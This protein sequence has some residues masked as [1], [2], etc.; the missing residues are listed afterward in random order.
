MG[1][2]TL[3]TLVTEMLGP[4]GPLI[5]I[6]VLGIILIMLAISLYANR[7]V[8]PYEKFSQQTRAMDAGLPKADRLR[9]GKNNEQLDKYST[10]LEP[11]DAEEFSAVK[12]RLLQAGYRGQDAVRTYHFAQFAL[13]LGLLALG[14]IFVIYQSATSEP[15]TQKMV[16]TAL[17]PGVIGYMAPKYWVTKRLQTRQEEITN[18]FPDALDMMLV[19]VEAGQ[20]LDQSILR[21]AT[22]IR[23]SFPALA[24]EYLLVSQEMKAGKDRIQVL[25]DLS[26]RANV[27]DVSSF[28]TV[29]IQSQTFGTS[30]AE[31]LR[32]YSD[33]MR[34]K[35]VMRAEEKANTLPTKMTLATMMLTVPPLLIILIGPSIYDIYLSFGGGGGESAL[36]F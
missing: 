7:R 31:A 10:F 16:L 2:D 35:R 25:R 9:Q 27:Q 8:D 18:G 14:A 29:L 11:K 5:I 26:E 15:T 6:G 1:M 21:V 34:D 12:L 33:E 28:V 3:F 24:D 4:F 20:S 23:P 17:I 30:I 32:V 22:E 36:A 19:C 13:G